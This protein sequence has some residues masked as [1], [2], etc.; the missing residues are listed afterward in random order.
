ML[1]LE[2]RG[3]CS[4]PECKEYRYQDPANGR[5]HPFCSRSHASEARQIGK[6]N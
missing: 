2:E 1:P 3:E 4:L 6:V 5:V